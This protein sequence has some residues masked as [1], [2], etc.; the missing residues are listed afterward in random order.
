MIRSE[1]LIH[2]EHFE[3]VMSL[4]VLLCHNGNNCYVL[5][6]ATRARL[7][8]LNRA[9]TSGNGYNFFTVQSRAH[10]TFGVIPRGF[11]VTRIFPRQ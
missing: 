9:Y 11:L 6:M 4:G 3:E 10:E 8:S 7:E 1:H 5:P 2:V